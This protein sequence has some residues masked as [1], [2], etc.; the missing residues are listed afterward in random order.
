M[1][2]EACGTTSHIT[3]HGHS[4]KARNWHKA[5]WSR[6]LREGVVGSLIMLIP[7]LL[8]GF[9]LSWWI[10]VAIIGVTATSAVLSSVFF[11]LRGHRPACSVKKGLVLVMGWWERL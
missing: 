10:G 9:F 8:L 6:V 4:G 2:T 1:D 5:G 7:A 11:S 3:L